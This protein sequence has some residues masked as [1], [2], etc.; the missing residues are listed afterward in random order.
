V[1]W[2][3]VEWSEIL[4]NRMS[5]IIRLFICHMKF[6]AYVAYC[7]VIF[8]HILLVSFLSLYIYIYIQ[9]VTGVT[10]QT[11]GGCSLC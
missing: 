5:N 3:A 9:G 10:D 11:S 6:A 2:S 7:L 8:F 1:N 4:C